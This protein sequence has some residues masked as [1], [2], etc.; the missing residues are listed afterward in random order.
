MEKNIFR[1][2]NGRNSEQED[3]LKCLVKQ[4]LTI[5][6]GPLQN[7]RQAAPSISYT[8]ESQDLDFIEDILSQ[9]AQLHT[10]SS[11][12]VHHPEVGSCV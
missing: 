4:M 12:A 3:D 6:Q 7:G 9:T 2:F 8:C 5:I 1:S 11:V 10:V